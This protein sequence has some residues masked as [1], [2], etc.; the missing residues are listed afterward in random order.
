M[1]VLWLFDDCLINVRKLFRQNIV[2]ALGTY[3]LYTFIYYLIWYVYQ[4]IIRQTKGPWKIQSALIYLYRSPI[5]KMTSIFYFCI[6][7]ITYIHIISKLGNISFYPH[8]KLLKLNKVHRKEEKMCILSSISTTCFYVHKKVL[9]IAE[10][11]SNMYICLLVCTRVWIQVLLLP[12][13]RSCPH[14]LPARLVGYVHGY[15]KISTSK[16]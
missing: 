14:V 4:I 10:H 8:K 2:K 5:Q 3:V 12:D 13:S 7:E 1:T 16:S 11:L 9:E 6:L 15:V